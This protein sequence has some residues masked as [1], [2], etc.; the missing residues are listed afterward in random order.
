[1]T[2]KR[3]SLRADALA[4][5]LGLGMIGWGILN[6]R[7]RLGYLP[8][9]IRGLSWFHPAESMIVGLIGLLFILVGAF[10]LIEALR[11]RR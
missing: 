6:L 7:A 5:L 10:R 2:P 4:I 3:E 11:A 9:D 1:M 8:G